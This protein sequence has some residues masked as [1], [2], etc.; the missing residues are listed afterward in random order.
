MAGIIAW[1]SESWFGQIV[2]FFLS[3]WS[4]KQAAQ[5]A[6][7]QAEQNAEQQHSADGA[8]SVL[9]QQSDDAQNAALDGLA[10]QL[11]NP[12]QGTVTQPPGATQPK[13]PS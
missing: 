10:N 7:N 4:N 3:W 11:D 8:Q 9:D 1:L 12:I 6:A 5:N 2:S 13:G